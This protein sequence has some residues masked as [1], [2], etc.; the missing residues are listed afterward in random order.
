MNDS[1]EKYLNMLSILKRYWVFCETKQR[2]EGLPPTSNSIQHHIERANYQTM[3]WKRC[4]RP[5]QGLPSPLGNG[6]QM[7][8]NVIMPVLITKEAAPVAI[9]ELTVL[10]CEKASCRSNHHCICRKNE[11][12]C[13]EGCG[14]MGNKN[15]Q[16][17]QPLQVLSDNSSDKEAW[18]FKAL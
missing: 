14:C 7:Y 16:N 5:M 2:N 13:T 18:N 17:P 8:D 6:W 15:C 11:R 3:V 12:P 4:L 10:K 9:M 1:H